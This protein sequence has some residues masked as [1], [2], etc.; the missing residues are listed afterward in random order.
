MLLRIVDECAEIYFNDLCLPHESRRF[1]SKKNF[2]FTSECSVQLLHKLKYIVEDFS[3]DAEKF[4]SGFYGLLLDNLLPSKFEDETVTNILLTEAANHILIHLFGGSDIVTL[5]PPSEH[6][7]ADRDFKSLQYIAGYIVH[8][9]YTKFKF[10]KNYKSDH[11]QQILSILKACKVGHDDSQTLVNLTDRGGLWKVNKEMQGIFIEREKIFRARTSTVQTSIDSTSLVS[12]MLQNCHVVEPKV[13]DE[14]CFNIL[15]KMP[16]LFTRV[17]SFSYAKDIREKY[18]SKK[19]QVKK[20]SL[21]TEIKKASSST[22]M[23]H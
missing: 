17:R 15:E 3:G 2:V 7:L 13:P 11:S 19:K 1:F 14:I 18:K 20:S 8:K 21:R 5:Q 9:M 16:M 10:S 6:V 12:E 22:D 23:G 4:Y